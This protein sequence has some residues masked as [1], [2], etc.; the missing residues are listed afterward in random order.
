[1]SQCSDLL[2]I[3][4]YSFMFLP[5][6]LILTAEDTAFFWSMKALC[7]LANLLG[8]FFCGPS[9]RNI[10][11]I[12][13][14]THVITIGQKDANPWLVFDIPF[15]SDD[16]V[17]D[18]GGGYPCPVDVPR[19]ARPQYP[20]GKKNSSVSSILKNTARSFN[21]LTRGWTSL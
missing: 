4:Y 5:S 6:M 17:F 14:R 13:N 20:A 19:V 15:G 18:G 12:N 21:G 3:I 7:S 10:I 1:M 9:W 8:F 2:N 11:A 16:V